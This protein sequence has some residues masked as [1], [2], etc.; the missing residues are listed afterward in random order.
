LRDGAVPG[1]HGI[2]GAAPNA[3]VTILRPCWVYGPGLAPTTFLPTL[4]ASLAA[5]RRYPMT[6][7]MQTRDLIFCLPLE[8]AC[9]FAESRTYT[10]VYTR[11]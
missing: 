7:G 6:P 9:E 1:E 2:V 3:K 8:V 4:I 11:R 5:R 10:L